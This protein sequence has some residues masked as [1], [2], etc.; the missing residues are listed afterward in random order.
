MNDCSCVCLVMIIL[1]NLHNKQ[2]DYTAS[3]LPNPLDH[4]VYVEMPKMFTSPGKVWLL[5]VALYGLKD[6]PR[7]YFIHN[8]NKLKDLGFRQSDTGPCLFISPTVTLL[9]YCD[10]CLLLYKSPEAVDI[11]TTKMKNAGMLFEEESDVA[12]YLG[13]LI[14]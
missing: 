8:K 10:N 11:L 4:D 13:M 2:I 6:T 9:C 3:F 12:G 5:K 7:A 14:D 1:L